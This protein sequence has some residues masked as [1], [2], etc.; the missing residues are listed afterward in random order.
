MTCEALRFTRQ[1][2]MVKSSHILYITD[3]SHLYTESMANLTFFFLKSNLISKMNAHYIVD[4]Y[5]C[6]S[7]VTNSPFILRHNIGYSLLLHHL[8]TYNSL[9]TN[10]QKYT[11]LCVF[12]FCVYYIYITLLLPLTSSLSFL[13]TYEIHGLYPIIFILIIIVI[14]KV[15]GS[16]IFYPYI[17]LHLLFCFILFTLH[18]IYFTLYLSTFYYIYHM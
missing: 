14:W 5:I 8:N 6:C 9:L 11:Y 2:E 17:F 7:C 12:K 4:I 3:L 1:W 10:L 18:I 16:G 13:T 15:R